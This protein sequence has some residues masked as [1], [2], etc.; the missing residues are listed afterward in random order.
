MQLSIQ[1]KI[2]YFEFMKKQL[3][4]ASISHTLNPQEMEFTLLKIFLI[5]LLFCNH[6][7]YGQTFEKKIAPNFN[8]SIIYGSEIKEAYFYWSQFS[9]STHRVSQFFFACFA[10]LHLCVNEIVNK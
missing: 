5:L 4:Q 2:G 6:W 1:K 9:Q 7:V 3:N 8:G 10:P